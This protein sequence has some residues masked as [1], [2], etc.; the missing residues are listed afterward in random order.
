MA[1]DASTAFGSGSRRGDGLHPNHS[2]RISRALEVFRQTGISI[3]QWQR[4]NT[5]EARG[6]LSRARPDDRATLHARIET[7]FDHAGGGFVEEVETLF[8][9]GDLHT[10]LPAIRAVGYRQI[11]SHLSGECSLEDTRD[12]GIAATRQLA[13]RQI[14][15][16]GWSGPLDRQ[17]GTKMVKSRSRTS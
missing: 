2:Q 17:R 15:F 7:R 1:R 4:A 16:S 14:S 6:R 8:D 10:D 13:K 12:K 3:S 11:W 9:R 5:Q